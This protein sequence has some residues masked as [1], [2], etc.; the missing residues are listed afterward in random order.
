MASTITAFY[1]FAAQTLIR[2]AYMNSNFDAFRGDHIPINIGSATSSDNAHDLGKADH[3]WKDIHLGGNLIMTS[4]YIKWDTASTSL[5]FSN[6]SGASYVSFLLSNL[7]VLTIGG[8]AFRWDTATSQLQ[9]SN[10]TTASYSGF[11]ASGAENLTIG[12][13]VLK[14]NTATS[15]LQLSNDSAVSFSNIRVEGATET[16]STGLIKWDTAAAR[17]QF[18]NDS[19]VSWLSFHGKNEE[20]LTFGTSVIKVNTATSRLQF[21]DNSGVS[22]TNFQAEIVESVSI[23]AGGM[24]KWETATSKL[25]FSNNSGASYTNFQSEIIESVSIG[26]GGMIQWNTATSKL[27]FSNDSGASYSEFGS[28]G[29]GGGGIIWR[30]TEVV[31]PEEDYEYGIPTLKFD[32]QSSQSCV[33]VLAVPETYVGGTQVKLKYGRLWSDAAANNILFR[34]VTSLVKTGDTSGSFANNY[35]STNA[36][37]TLTASEVL[38]AIGDLDLCAAA[39]TIGS[40]VVAAGDILR[41]RFYRSIAEETAF[42]TTTARV[43]RDG[44]YPDFT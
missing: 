24:I 31:S 10:D 1:S 37:L 42:A 17:M 20:S 13:S 16:F 29:G 35:T 27:E 23:G 32:Y 34:T 36:Q 43:I 39:G 15:K 44:F 21:S 8:G 25:Q 28:G 26:A 12:S 38:L 40:G 22:Y 33:G 9:F 4:G 5:Q 7:S 41:V 3:R 6:N 18:S 30:L 11:H 2:S 19:A 14:V